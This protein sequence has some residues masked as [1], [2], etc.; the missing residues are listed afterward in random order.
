MKVCTVEHDAD[1]FGTIPVG[2]LWADDSPYVVDADKFAEV[3]A[4]PVAPAVAKPV[5]KFGQKES[6]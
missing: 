5:R 4:E 2:S 6:A 1:G 3:E